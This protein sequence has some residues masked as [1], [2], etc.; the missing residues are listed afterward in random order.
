MTEES[1]IEDLRREQKELI[2]RITDE[3]VKNTISEFDDVNLSEYCKDLDIYDM[4]RE[5]VN[6]EK[7]ILPDFSSFTKEM[8][9]LIFTVINFPEEVITDVTDSLKIG[10]G[11]IE[12]FLKKKGYNRKKIFKVKREI[13][14]CIK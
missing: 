9:H 1:K 10:L 12:R 2:E 14:E 5:E 4:Y 13:R 11:S 7:S 8:Q 3:V 6:G